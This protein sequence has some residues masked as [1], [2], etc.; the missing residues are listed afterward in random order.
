MR[1]VR[2]DTDG[3][4]RCHNCGSTSLHRK[5][6]GRSWAIAITV[7]ILTLGIWLIIFLALVKPK[8]KCMACGEW[9]DQ[10]NAKPYEPTSQHDQEQ[11]ES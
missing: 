9:N 2:I 11:Q 5:R 1:N 3:Q 4:L 7:G 8:L 10:G 6:T